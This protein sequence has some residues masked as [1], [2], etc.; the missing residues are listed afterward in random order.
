MKYE[1]RELLGRVLISISAIATAV[2]A[3]VF[4]WSASHLFNPTW[5]N[6]VPGL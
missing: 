1:T 4:D 3:F 5:P 2:A 6:H